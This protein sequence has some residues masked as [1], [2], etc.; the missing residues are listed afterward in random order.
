MDFVRLAIVVFASGAVVA[1]LA[2]VAA[3]SGRNVPGWRSLKPGV[4]HWTGIYLGSGLVLFMGYIRLFVGSSRADGPA[5]MTILSCLILVFGVLLLGTS[6]AVL[7]LRRQAVRW[8]GTCVVFN[9]TAGTVQRD[10]ATI[11]DVQPNALGQIIL[12]FTD[13]IRLRIDPYA[14]SAGD[15]LDRIDETR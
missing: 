7:A 12:T 5:Q 14:T 10:F 11:A 8:R 9:G 15:L 1:G 6:F 13:G 4:L 3:A 2:A